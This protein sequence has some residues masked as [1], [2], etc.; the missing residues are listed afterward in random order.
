MEVLENYIDAKVEIEVNA[1]AVDFKLLFK[2]T[3]VKELWSKIKDTDL[4]TSQIMNFQGVH[5]YLGMKY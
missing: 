2:T 4:E 3:G 1:L 5:S